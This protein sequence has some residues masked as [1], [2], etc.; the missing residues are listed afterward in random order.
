MSRLLTLVLAA[1]VL[2]ASGAAVGAPEVRL[3]AT[4]S[5]VAEHDRLGLAAGVGSHLAALPHPL[6]LGW[7]VDLVHH[8]VDVHSDYNEDAQVNLLC[9]N[10]LGSV[11]VRSTLGPI[12]AGLHAVGGPRFTLGSSILIDGTPDDTGRLPPEIRGAGI[13]V[14]LEVAITGQR[15]G[16]RVGWYADQAGALGNYPDILGV[17]FLSLDD[18]RVEYAIGQVTWAF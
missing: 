8:A 6:S 2:C 17:P 5:R 10:V 13:L 15:A 4:R 1:V 12:V 7:A 3:G 11:G 16:A 9:L 14:G 18:R